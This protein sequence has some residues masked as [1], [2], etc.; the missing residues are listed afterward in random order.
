V[1]VQVL[2]VVIH[3]AADESRRGHE[4]GRDGDLVLETGSASQSRAHIRGL[5]HVTENDGIECLI[6]LSTV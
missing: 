1:Y 2:E 6:M 4:A 5:I 3:A